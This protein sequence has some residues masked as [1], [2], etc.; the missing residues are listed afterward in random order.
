M[1]TCG[2]LKERCM[3]TSAFVLVWTFVLALT[4]GYIYKRSISASEI[5]SLDDSG[6]GA[7]NKGARGRLCIDK[8]PRG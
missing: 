8:N 5:A 6:G 7:E 3:T 4:Q 1:K 2:I